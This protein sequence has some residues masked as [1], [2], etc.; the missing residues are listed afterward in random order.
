[1]SAS[2]ATNSYSH[3]PVPGSFAFINLPPQPLSAGTSANIQVVF[4]P[5]NTVNYAS[6]TTTT[7]VVVA[8]TTPALTPP[9]TNYAVINQAL[10]LSAVSGGAANNSYNQANVPGQFS[11][12]LASLV[13]A[14]LG[15]TNFGVTFTP[16]DGNDYTTNATT[17]KV[18]VIAAPTNPVPLLITANN[19]NWDMAASPN[20]PP[21]FTVK[22]VGLNARDLYSGNT[23]SLV[24]TNTVFGTNLSV[25][26]P[27]AYNALPNGTYT[28]FIIPALVGLTNYHNYV[29]SYGWGN[30]TITNNSVVAVEAAVVSNGVVASASLAGFLGN[31]NV[32][33]AGLNAVLA[34]YLNQSPPHFGDSSFPGG[35]NLSFT[36][37]NFAFSVQYNTNLSAPNGWHNLARPV[38]FVV[39]DTNAVTSPNRYYRLVGSTNY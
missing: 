15:A 34:R 32:D 12:T 18:V 26:T 17:V 31:Y 38:R 35:T 20:A 4:N 24:G 10:G 7:S 2:R 13:P 1:L 11:Y 30:L 29:V 28:N 6:A 22:C 33:Q 9:G 23:S 16:Y 19:A 36:I 27:A 14:R 21:V 25:W 37:T 8:R 5:S 3:V 39:D